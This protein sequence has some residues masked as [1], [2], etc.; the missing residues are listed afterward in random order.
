MA[1][2]QTI[3]VK[4][5]GTDHHVVS[6]YTQDDVNSKRLRPMSSRQDIMGLD[7]PPQIFN[8]SDFR[9]PPRVETRKNGQLRIV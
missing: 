6:Y 7:L 9:H 5:H 2:L 4:V 1:Y 3:T 8:F